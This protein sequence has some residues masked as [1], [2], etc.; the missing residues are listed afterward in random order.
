M[1]IGKKSNDREKIK[2]NIEH[3][4]TPYTHFPW[5]S[6]ANGLTF[7][8]PDHFLCMYKYPYVGMWERVCV[9]I[10]TKGKHV[11]VWELVVDIFV[12]GIYVNGWRVWCLG[13]SI[14]IGVWGARLWWNMC[15]RVS[16][17]CLYS[18]ML[19][20][21]LYVSES[22]CESLRWACAEMGWREDM[23]W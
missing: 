3:P 9:C 17:M 1:L 13:E 16:Q 7:S 4:P 5:V 2:V 20:V 14:C 8:L 23:C 15:W 18:R 22:A 11:T 10:W 21:Y 6:M 19:W 12:C